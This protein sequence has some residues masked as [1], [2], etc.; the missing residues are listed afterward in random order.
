MNSTELLLKF[1]QFRR[2]IGMDTIFL[3]SSHVTVMIH[4]QQQLKIVLRIQALDSSL[5]YDLK[6]EDSLCKKKPTAVTLCIRTHCCGFVWKLFAMP[7]FR[8]PIEE[9]LS[10]SFFKTTLSGRS[11]FQLKFLSKMNQINKFSYPQPLIKIVSL[12]F[13]LEQLVFHL[14]VTWPYDER[15]FLN[16]GGGWNQLKIFFG[17]SLRGYFHSIFGWNL[18]IFKRFF[19]GG[20]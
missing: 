5:L 11:L 3:E 18:R 4:Y 12:L 1:L 2:F 8:P 16:V 15:G 14:W 7:Y 6:V 10:N 19:S 13:L 9:K 20:C 17:G